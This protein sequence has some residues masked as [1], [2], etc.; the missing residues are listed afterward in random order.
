MYSMKKVKRPII[1][2]LLDKLVAAGEDGTAYLCLFGRRLICRNGR[3]V[4]WYRP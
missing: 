1:H 3:Y 2:K 4:G